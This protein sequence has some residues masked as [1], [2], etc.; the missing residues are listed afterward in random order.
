MLVSWPDAIVFALAPLGVLLLIS[1]PRTF[2]ERVWLATLSAW[3]VLWLFQ[4][5]AY[6]TQMV[7]G[8]GVLVTGAFVVATLLKPM[9]LGR[10]IGA[11]MGFGVAGIVWWGWLAGASWAQLEFEL[12]RAT[13]ESY[14]AM[15]QLLEAMGS[16]A[17]QEDA[18]AGITMAVRLFPGMTILGAVAGL[19]VAWT[20]Y[21]RVATSPLGR[22]VG[23]FAAFRGSDHLLWGLVLALFGL[24]GPWRESLEVPAVNALL[25]FGAVY[26]ARGAAILTWFVRSR[27]MGSVLLWLLALAAL[28]VLPI[29]GSGLLLLGIV[30]IWVDIRRPRPSPSGT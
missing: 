20:V 23:P 15:A 28:F 9:A 2:R 14:Q 16:T 18:A 4:P 27:P 21:Q 7:R 22:P 11:A 3:A 12:T 19:L 29:A 30:D 6:I 13:W 8:M 25:V 1:R 26:M 10:N 5:G 24:V 17:S